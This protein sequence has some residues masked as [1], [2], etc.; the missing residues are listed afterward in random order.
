M[1]VFSNYNLKSPWQQREFKL[2]GLVLGLLAAG[3][4]INYL[5]YRVIF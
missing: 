4:V 5:V 3:F 1:Y 2:V